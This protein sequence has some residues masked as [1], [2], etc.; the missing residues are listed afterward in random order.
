[1]KNLIDDL[2]DSGEYPEPDEPG[3]RIIY[4][5]FPQSG[6]AYSSGDEPAAGG[7]GPEVDYDRPL[8]VDYGWVAWVN[9]DRPSTR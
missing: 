2:I 3:G 5:V 9:F 7:H 6:T 8:E 1:V 4:M